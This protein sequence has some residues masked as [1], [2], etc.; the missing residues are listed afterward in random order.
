MNHLFD[1]KIGLEKESL[2]IDKSGRLAQ[3]RHLFLGNPNIDRDFCEN[4]VEIIT[5]PAGSPHDAYLEIKKLHQYVIK[6]LIRQGEYLWLFSNPPY[7]EN[8]DEIPVAHFTGSLSY[9]AKYRRYLATKYGKRK[10]L[11]SGIH[12]NFSFGENLLKELFKNSGEKDYFTFVNSLYLHLA[13]WV[14]RYSWLIV[15]LTAASPLFDESFFVNKKDKH[16]NRYASARCSEIG[17]NNHFIPVIDYNNISSYIKSIEHYVEN[18]DIIVPSELYYPVRLKS[19][20]VNSLV[21]LGETGVNHIELRMLDLNPLSEA[22]I[23]E[24][25]IAFI[26]LLLLYLSNQQDFEFTNEMQTEAVKKMYCAA[27]YDN[28]EFADEA[29]AIIDKINNYFKGSLPEYYENALKYQS[30][31][32]ANPEKRYA[33]KIR[34]QFGNSFS[35]KGFEFSKQT[36]N[37]LIKRARTDDS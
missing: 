26:H 28:D 22:G 36:T 11:Y 25:D 8:D 30:E 29:A 4:Q 1:C 9:K 2:R 3:T 14:V 6:E 34:K 15:F 21:T 13:K 16:L 10:M 24:E 31:K 20:G 19:S 17:Y 23:F 27:L 12:Y 37:L 18:G 7:F 5:N 32:I 35:L 33:V